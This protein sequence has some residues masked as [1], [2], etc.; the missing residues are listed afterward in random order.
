MP[1][2]YLERGK[3]TTKLDAYALGMVFLELLTGQKPSG[4]L[5]GIVRQHL[6]TQ[7]KTTMGPPFQVILDESM[8]EDD[9]DEGSDGPKR[10]ANIA[11]DML[12]EEDE[13][14][15]SVVEAMPLLEAIV[16]EDKMA[17]A[18]GKRGGK[19]AKRKPRPKLST[20]DRP[21]PARARGR[22]KAPG[23]GGKAPGSGGSGGSDALRRR[24]R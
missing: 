1:P 3:I 9:D 12:M 15:L 8:W 18:K 23:S 10:L 24:R 16:D 13:E 5:P 11:L 19:R 6:P 14:R 22:T 20:G 7:L 21:N 2:E 17:K 4:R